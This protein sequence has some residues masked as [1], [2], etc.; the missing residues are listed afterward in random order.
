[1]QKN[2][3][4]EMYNTVVQ[5]CYSYAHKRPARVVALCNYSSPGEH[6]YDDYYTGKRFEN[7][8]GIFNNDS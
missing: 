1:M 4:A 2:L 6:N 3:V 8:N 7:V 5:K